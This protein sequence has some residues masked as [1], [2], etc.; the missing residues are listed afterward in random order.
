M[1]VFLNGPAQNN[2]EWIAGSKPLQRAPSKPLLLKR[3]PHYLRATIHQQSGDLDGLD[4]LE[5]TPSEFEDVYAYEMIGEPSSVH[6]CARGKNRAAGGWYQG[7]RYK[8]C[9]PQPTDRELRSTPHWREWVSAR[10]GKP[11]AAD[12]TVAP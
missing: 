11:V 6:I 3:A 1:T 12:G 2:G 9:D 8:L 5:D 4:Q 7:G 10:I